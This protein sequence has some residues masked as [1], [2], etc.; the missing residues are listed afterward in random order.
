MIANNKPL[1]EKHLEIV[2]SVFQDNP[3]KV[4]KLSEIVTECSGLT[5]TMVMQCLTYLI[6]KN[7]IAKN[8]N[9]R[10]YWL[11]RQS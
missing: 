2:R 1:R 3:D 9:L 6:A 11:I 5:R 10:T 4:F 8:E 7:I